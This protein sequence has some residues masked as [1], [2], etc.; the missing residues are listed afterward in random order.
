MD[1][2]NVIETVSARGVSFR[3]DGDQILVQAPTEPDD[4]TK[5]LIDRLRDHRDEVRQLLIAPVCW[6]CGA[7]MTALSLIENRQQIWVCWACAKLA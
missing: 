5:A 6:Q 1:I 7:L 4:S 2:K 3:L